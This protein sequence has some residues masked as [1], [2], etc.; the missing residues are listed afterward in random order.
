MYRDFL[1]QNTF[2]ISD[3][4]GK[5]IIDFFISNISCY[6]FS[7]IDVNMLNLNTAY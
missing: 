2:L 3:L 5:K 4:I 7:F 6:V 1:F